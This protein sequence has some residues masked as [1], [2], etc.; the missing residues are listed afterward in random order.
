MACN[1]QGF[2]QVG[3]STFRLPEPSAECRIKKLIIF[4]LLIAF[5]LP[6]LLIIAA[7]MLMFIPSAPLAQNPLLCVRFSHPHSRTN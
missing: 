2:V 5:G 1:V 6:E 3:N 7:K 4:R